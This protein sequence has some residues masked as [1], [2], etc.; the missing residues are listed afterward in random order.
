MRRVPAAGQ[1]HADGLCSLVTQELELL[2]FLSCFTL[3]IKNKQ[4]KSWG[5]R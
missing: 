4:R 5:N 2:K 1:L 3:F